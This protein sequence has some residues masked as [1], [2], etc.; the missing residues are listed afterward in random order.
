MLRLLGYTRK[1]KKQKHTVWAEILLRTNSLKLS[2]SNIYIQP[3][4]WDGAGRP[5]AEPGCDPHLPEGPPLA[6]RSLWHQGCRPSR[7]HHSKVS[8]PITPILGVQSSCSRWKISFYV[9][10]NYFVWIL[11]RWVP[12][13]SVILHIVFFSCLVLCFSLQRLSWWMK[14]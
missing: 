10:T 9:L 13:V 7:D 3:A 5:C 12:Q 11:F 6:W 2:I 14:N 8:F 4:W 1:K